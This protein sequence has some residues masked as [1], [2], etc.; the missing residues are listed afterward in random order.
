[1]QLHLNNSLFISIYYVRSVP[2][3]SLLKVNREHQKT[4]EMKV[5][6]LHKRILPKGL[7]MSPVAFSSPKTARIRPGTSIILPVLSF[8]TSYGT[9]KVNFGSNFYQI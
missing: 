1:M 9:S 5:A 4:P 8:E 6:L 2:F 3:S 7:A